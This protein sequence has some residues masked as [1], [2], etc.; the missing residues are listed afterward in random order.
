MFGFGEIPRKKMSIMWA[1]TNDSFKAEKFTASRLD[2]ILMNASA[3]L[4]PD[5]AV[6]ALQLA[7]HMY[8]EG[9]PNSPQRAIIRTNLIASLT[10]TTPG[11]FEEF[12]SLSPEHAQILEGM[13][14]SFDSDKLESYLRTQRSLGRPTPVIIDLDASNLDELTHSGGKM[15][16]YFSENPLSSDLYKRLKSETG[17]TDNTFNPASLTILIMLLAQFGSETLLDFLDRLRSEQVEISTLTAVRILEDWDNLS[18][19]PIDWSAG[20]LEEK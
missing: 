12:M 8:G 2:E 20:L 13:I 4:G 19:F 1:G 9:G 16:E 5:I 11:L 17:P 10:S 14:F 3:V 7:T 15:T 6:K 18:A